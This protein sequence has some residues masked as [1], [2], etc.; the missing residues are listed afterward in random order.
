MSSRIS[1]R[2][3]LRPR[4]VG[5]DMIVGLVN[6]MPDGALRAT[7]RQFTELLELASARCA[8]RPT[9]RWFAI[10]EVPRGPVGLAHV[11]QHYEDVNRL[12]TDRVDGLIVTGAE[13]RAASLEDEPYWPTLVKLIDWAAA[14]TLSSLW[15]CLAAHAAVYHLNGIVRRQLPEKLSGVF[16]CEQAGADPL[17]AGLPPRWG[18]PHSRLN[19]LPEDAL[20]T[21]GYRVLSRLADGGVDMFSKRQPSLFVFM[22]GHPEYECGTL[23][24]EY[25]RD[26]ARYLHG[27]RSSYPS[28]PR[29]YFDET[30]IAKFEDL[31]ERVLE[32]RDPTLISALQP[33]DARAEPPRSWHEPA[34]QLYANWLSYIRSRRLEAMAG[35]SREPKTLVS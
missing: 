35:R 34:V 14:N 2:R 22:Q 25:Q 32:R 7:E 33:N 11:H 26:I 15:S 1:I 21:A 27:E 23:L 28:M 24:R 31:Q 9:V 8:E 6:N 10:P 17:L 20:A 4:T 5:R 29:N 19:D 18:V 13:P 3:S 12:L 16:P 30:M